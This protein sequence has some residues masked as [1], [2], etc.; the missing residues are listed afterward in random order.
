MSEMS[1]MC[2]LCSNK[3]PLE[4]M[5]DKKYCDFNQ[6]YDCLFCM[7]SNDKD[8]LNGSMGIK[9]KDY[10]EISLK[11]HALIHEI[12]CNRLGDTGG[13]YVCMKL[14]DIPF[15]IPFEMPFEVST[16]KV[17]NIQEDTRINKK[18]ITEEKK[19]QV[20]EYKSHNIIINNDNLFHSEDFIITI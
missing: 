14:L 11:H 1:E 9:L 7:N 6:C 3:Y 4:M 19:T 17:D 13:C 12:P 10:I 8:I 18:S 15:E 2:E 20:D 5:I 16:D